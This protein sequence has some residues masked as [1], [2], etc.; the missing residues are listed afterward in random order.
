MENKK[1]E[2]ENENV[3]VTEDDIM[4]NIILTDEEGNETEFEVIAHCERNGQ[5]YFAMIPAGEDDKDND[6]LEYVVLK[7]AVE[8][9]EEV[10]ISVDDDDELDDIA[11]YFDDLLS[12]E[13]DYDN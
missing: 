2:N 9:G 13:F 4:D 5:K 8:D 11:D 6:I 3:L 10:L 1:I 12:Q 7:L